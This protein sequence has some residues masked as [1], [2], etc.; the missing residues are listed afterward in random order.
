MPEKFGTFGGRTLALKL[1]AADL[2]D[3]ADLAKLTGGII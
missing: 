1:R 3:F 2:S